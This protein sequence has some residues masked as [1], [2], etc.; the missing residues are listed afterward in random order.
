MQHFITEDA[1]VTTDNTIEIKVEKASWADSDCYAPFVKD[2]NGF[3]REGQVNYRI[4]EGDCSVSEAV[5][6]YKN[7]IKPEGVFECPH[8]ALLFKHPKRFL[9]HNKWHTFGLTNIKRMEIAKVREQ[10]R[11]ERKEAKIIERMNSKEVTE[12]VSVDGKTFPCKD[13]DKVFSSK[14]SLKNH[15]Q[16]SH[17]TRTRECKICHKSMSTWAALRVHMAT[18]TAESGAGYQCRECPKRF[19]YSHSL[20]K[21]SDTHLEKTHACTDCPKKFGSQALLKMH[22]KTHERMLRGATFSSKSSLKNHR[23]RSHPTRIRECKICHKS[24]STWAA[25]RVH[26]ATHTAESGA[27]YQCRE[28]PK[29]FKYSHSLAK[30]SDTHLEKTHACTDCPKK[31]G[32]QALLKMH[33]KTHERMLRGATFRCTYCGKGFFESY[34]LQVHE[35][36]HRNERPYSCDICNT[37]FGT[38]SSLKR[39]LKVSHSTSKPHQCTVCHRNFSTESIRDRH[40]SRVHGKPEDFKFPCKQCA[41]KSHPTRIRECKICHKSMSTWAALR[42]HMATHTAESGAG[43]QCR[44]CPKRFKYSHSLAKHSDT[45]LEKTHACT[46][47]PKKFGSQALLKMHMKT[48][49]RMLRGATF[50]CTYCGKGFFESYSLQVHERTHRNER[51]YSCDI[52]NTAFGTN[53]SLKR[54]LKVSHSTSKPHQCTVCRRNFSTES[55][56]DRHE[57]RVHGKPE[58][59]KFPCKQCACKY[60]KLKDLQK[61]VYKMHPKGKRKKKSKSSESE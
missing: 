49:E 32:S 20:A 4:I 33:M 7:D 14:S 12:E 16:R 1:E 59:F 2:V 22:M 26:M 50:R 39:H 47:C 17:P 28:C 38:N 55:I 43:Y 6:A 61:H 31:F 23:Q 34:S 48:H 29:R 21:H 52:C 3:H 57:S 24:M 19:K 13:C 53:S 46:D 36:T 41:C 44:E 60:L 9:I 8:C 18:H 30:H 54:H 5:A 51:P 56:R 42:V 45:H 58:D 37:A 40:E 15:R 35:R 10:K 11:F 27:G 25:L